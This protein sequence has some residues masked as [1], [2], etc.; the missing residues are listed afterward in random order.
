MKKYSLFI[1]I[2][3][4]MIFQLQ[5]EPVSSEWG[6]GAA[7]ADKDLSIEEMLNYAVQD[8][9]LAQGLNM[10]QLSVNSAAKNRFQIL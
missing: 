4:L 2:S 1:I 8:E 5:A 10:R 7:S 9:Y 3:F 6:A